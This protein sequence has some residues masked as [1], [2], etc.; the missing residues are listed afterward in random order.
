MGVSQKCEGY[1][2]ISADLYIRTSTERARGLEGDGD[3]GAETR[4]INRSHR[5]S[6]ATRPRTRPYAFQ[7]SVFLSSCGHAVR[8]C[9][10]LDVG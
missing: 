8:R 1:D 7:R 10:R 6:R 3:C 4:K 5:S 2:E 9:G